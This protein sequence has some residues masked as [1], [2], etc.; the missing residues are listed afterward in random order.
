MRICCPVCQAPLKRERASWYCANGH[1]FDVARQGYV[2][3]LTAG[4][5]HSKHPGDTR[6]MVAAR[7]EF[8]DGGFYAPIASEVVRLLE[9]EPLTSV[10]DAGCGEGYYLTELS[11]SLP[12]AE[13]VG[14]DISKDAVRY[15]AGRN[16]NAV[17]LTATAAKLPFAEA[18]F[19]ALLWMFAMTAAEE[20]RR[21]LKPGGVFLQVLAGPE[22]LM[23]LK[24]RIYPTILHKPKL[25]HSQYEGFVLDRTQTLEFSFEL[26]SGRQ[27]QNL[28]AM[29]PHFWRISREAAQKLQELTQLTDTA[30]VIFNLY[31]AQ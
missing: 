28:L 7:K 10:L 18:S 3:L 19:D 16:P 22:H 23:G 29:T 26:V 12:Q 9:N 25:L 30:Q 24:N 2:N 8:L 5:K 21:V 4:Q 17:W 31:R 1:N 13:L 14:V 15:A 27:I 20:F 11:R 6:Q